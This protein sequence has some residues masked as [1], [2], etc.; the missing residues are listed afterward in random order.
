MEKALEDLTGLFQHLPWI[1]AIV[2][3]LAAAV[4]KKLGGFLQT[5][6]AAPAAQLKQEAE[7]EISREERVSMQDIYEERRIEAETH[8]GFDRTK[9]IFTEDTENK[10]QNRNGLQLPSDDTVRGMIWAEILGPPKAKQQAGSSRARMQR[11]KG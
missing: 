3:A 5:E 1:G 10:S 2:I 8:S 7:D 6:E 4:L 9:H 11:R